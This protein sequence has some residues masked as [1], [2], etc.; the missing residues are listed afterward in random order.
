MAKKTTKGKHSSQTVSLV[1]TR[2]E[3][4]QVKDTVRAAVLGNAFA[5]G[6]AA[7]V[8]AFATPTTPDTVAKIYNDQY[9]QDATL[10]PL[11][12]LLALVVRHDELATKL[13]FVL[14]PDELVFDRADVTDANKHDALLGFT[15]RR[16][17]SDTISL[18]TLM[19]QAKYRGH[20]QSG[21]AVRVAARLADYLARLHAMG[22]VFCD[23][24][25]KNTHVSKNLTEITFLD[26]DGYQATLGGTPIPSRG[27]TEGYASPAAIA[28][29]TR[30][31]SALRSAADDNFVLAILLFQLLVDRAHPFATGP[32]FVEHPAASHNDN[33]SARR[34]A[35]GDVGRFHPDSDAANLYARLVTPLKVAFYRSFLGQSPV[36]AAEWAKLLTTH[37]AAPLAATATPEP[38]ATA[39]TPT[40]LA[41]APVSHPRRPPSRP[42]R[43]PTRMVGAA[44]TALV[45]LPLAFGVVGGRDAKPSVAP[46]S[47]EVVS[48]ALTELVHPPARTRIINTSLS[49]EA[50]LILAELPATLDDVF[51]TVRAR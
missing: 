4:V 9:R 30:N 19:K 14:W 21:E 26:A 3:A 51:A 2:L 41:A 24:N 5:K 18:Y 39:L 12:K 31:A 6:A 8:Y 33:I 13:P 7:S 29:H 11:D 27:V 40:P 23:L 22:I 38:D 25:P 50:K 28:N 45:A 34:Y 35:F 37:V 36:T 47:N 32:Q 10:R 17:P 15:M 49:P 1:R 42:L 43:A 44:V 48:L 46:V 20:F 16:L